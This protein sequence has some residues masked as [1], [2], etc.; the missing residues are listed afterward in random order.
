MKI[1]YYFVKYNVNI[2]FN[3]ITSIKLI[4]NTLDILG[5]ENNNSCAFINDSTGPI[6]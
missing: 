1:C 5:I 3:S 2:D 4:R 6:Y